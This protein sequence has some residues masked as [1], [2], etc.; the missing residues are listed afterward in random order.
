[1]KTYFGQTALHL[2]ASKKGTHPLMEELISHLTAESNIVPNAPPN[3]LSRVNY[4]NKNVGSG[5]TPLHV[6][7]DA[8]RGRNALFLLENGTN[9]ETRDR[10]DSTAWDLA[11]SLKDKEERWEVIAAFILKEYRDS[12]YP[13]L[14]YPWE[15]LNLMSQCDNSMA[16]VNERLRCCAYLVQG[17]T[18]GGREDFDQS[19]EYLKCILPQVHREFHERRETPQYLSSREPSCVIQ[20]IE[21]PDSGFT[22]SKDFVSLAMP[23]IYVGEWATE[24]TRLSDYNKEGVKLT[25]C[26]GKPCDLF[27][28]HIPLT[29]DEYCSPALHP[30][31]LSSR[32]EDQVL[33]RQERYR[34]KKDDARLTVD[35]DTERGNVLSLLNELWILAQDY[36]S[37]L[38][39][40]MDP[41]TWNSPKHQRSM[42]TVAEDP[43]P[44]SA[45][46][47]HQVWIW[48][49]GDFAIVTGENFGSFAEAY[50]S[51]PYRGIALILKSIVERF[52]KP[53][54]LGDSKSLLK[55]YENE[56][57]VIS[58]EV[59]QYMKSA[60][61]KDIDIEQEKAFFH[62]ISDLR[63][64]VSMIKSVLAEQEEVWKEFMGSM[65]PNQG[66]G[67]RQN[68]KLNAEEM[69]SI[70]LQQ[71]PSGFETQGEWNEVWRPQALFNKYRRRI[72]KLEEDSERVE[73]NIS[74][75]LDL[76]Q[77]HAAMK[78]AHSAAILSTAVAG[79]TVITVIFAPL[80]FVV[81]LF[82]LPI[83]KF[84]DGKDGG[85][86][87]G[88]YSSNY[89]GK[90]SAATELVSITV[91]L[92]AMWA[93]LRFAGL[94]IW[95][96]KGL[97]ARVRQK[98]SEIRTRN[99]ERR[100]RPY[101]K[102]D[103]GWK[104]YY[105]EKGN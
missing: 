56:L 71:F 100:M 93:A 62:Q 70:A 24:E 28:H 97:R 94:H 76:K 68:R 104:V 16:M 7:A 74:T 44:S 39:S 15:D 4:V 66:L 49:V 85:Q 103:P 6:A 52:D 12:K 19:L 36:A 69:E 65:W 11:L 1:M 92:L 77:K 60:V 78:E 53:V 95:G 99:R 34:R 26:I 63:E 67:Q 10:T 72:A 91:T 89:I 84:N 40:L 58:E 50:R 41:R 59:N 37:K 20:T 96:K 35:G 33:S 79:F 17:G 48:K 73:R 43:P 55:I 18:R 88:V 101:G 46:F 90:W 42:E 64:E 27:Q 8:G 51:N 57:S 21:C 98:A 75:K 30:R 14:S 47:V 80:S 38:G 9:P 102:G 87:D 82:A 5:E 22:G 23:F 45:V 2:A 31:I 105:V 81:A 86:K 54:G 13:R 83:D 3:H 32:N 61:V 29:L 25:Y